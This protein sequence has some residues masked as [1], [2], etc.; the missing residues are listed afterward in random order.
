VQAQG[1][2]DDV[3]F[4]PLTTMQT[5]LN[6]TRPVR[7]SLGVSM[8]NVQLTDD[9]IETAQLAAEKI[10]RLLRERHGV[11][12]DDFTV[13]SQQDL[14]ITANQVTGF[15]TLFLGSVAS[16]SLLIGG[17][18]IMNIMLVSVTE[19]T[20]EIGIR[21]AIGAKRRNILMQ[22]LLEASVVSVIGG[23][24]GIVI[25]VGGSRLLDG[26]RFGGAQSEPVQTIITP[27]AILLAFSVSV[28]V[29][30]VFGMYPALRA[31]RLSPIE[32]LRYE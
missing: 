15:I 31:S 21:K 30:V 7:G 18:G 8:I 17:I 6:R 24:I 14:L 32:A 25:G 13:R 1:N 26:L 16:L 2:L 9:R 23:V 19:R 27:D 29:G 3:I 22:F 4:V 28:L 11:A 5:R 12:K 10:G 20:R